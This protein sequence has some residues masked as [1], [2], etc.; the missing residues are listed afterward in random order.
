VLERLR[1]FGLDCKA[2]KCQFEASKIG[3]LRFI[4]S[5]AGVGMESDRISTIEDWPTPESIRDV[6]VFLGFTNFYRQFIRK[7][8]K[9]TTPISDLLKIS[10]GKWA[11]T[12]AADLAFRKLNKAF[13]KAPIDQHFDPAR[14]IILQT[15]ASSFAIAGI[16]NQYDGFGILRPVNIYLQKY[17]PAKQNY[18]TYDWELLAIVQTSTQWRHYLE[19]SNHKILIQCD[20]NNLEYFKTSKVLSRM[21]MGWA[22]ILSSYDFVI[23][24]LEGKMN[25]ADGPSRRPDYDE[26]YKRPTTRLLATL[27]ATTVSPFDDLLQAIKA[28]QHTDPLPT[29]MKNEIDDPDL[30][31]TGGHD[32]SMDREADMQWKVIAGAPTFEGRIYVPQTL[33]NQVISLFYDNPE[34]GHFGALRT[35]ELVSRDI[36]G[37][38]QDT[39]LRKYV[40]CREVCHQNKAPCHAQY[41]VNMPR[42]PPYNPWDGITMDSVTNLRNQPSQHTPGF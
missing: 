18:N 8:A 2:E 5:S 9:E 3:F 11:W 39:T 22:E 33:R 12:R 28:A 31:K 16:L 37:L 17:S 30:P 6:Q 13:T 21:P 41:G 20:H 24:H 38:G 15:D 14:P 23:Q 40:A 7:Y 35:S 26:A 10:P 27:A 25:P 34:S 4:F 1:Q 36:Y 42:P 19:G 32:G 29:D